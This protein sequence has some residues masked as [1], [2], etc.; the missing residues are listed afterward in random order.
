MNYET[1]VRGKQHRWG[2]TV[3]TKR[4]AD[5]M[6]DDGIEVVEVHNS[7]PVWVVDFGLARIWCFFQDIWNWPSR[8]FPK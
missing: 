2:V 8:R 6:R 1:E 3:P 7:M 4:Q 5:A